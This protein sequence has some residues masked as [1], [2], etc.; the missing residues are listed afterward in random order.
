MNTYL[1]RV[2]ATLVGL[3]AYSTLSVSTDATAA[4]ALPST[5]NQVRTAQFAGVNTIEAM[6]YRWPHDYYAVVT[7]QPIIRTNVTVSGLTPEALTKKLREVAFQMA[8]LA[9]NY[10]STNNA[11]Q[12]LATAKEADIPT[13]FP[14]PGTEVPTTTLEMAQ[15]NVFLPLTNNGT[16]GLKVPDGLTAET[17]PI[18]VS[19]YVFLRFPNL[20]YFD[21]LPPLLPW[22]AQY[23]IERQTYARIFTSN[24]DGSVTEVRSKA[25]GAAIFDQVATNSYTLYLYAEDFKLLRLYGIG[26][27]GIHL[28]LITNGVPAVL[29]LEA[30]DGSTPRY[31][32]PNGQ[33]IVNPMITGMAIFNNTPKIGIVGLASQQIVVESSTTLFG[34]GATWV[35]EMSVQ[36]LPESGIFHYA[37]PMQV[38]NVP[39]ASNRFWRIRVVQ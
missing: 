19:E 31:W 1:N 21:Q 30:A 36:S 12:L 2:L 14:E 34:P 4:E 16:D 32:L 33:P 24:P 9:T 28:S 3:V 35:T 15:I 27:I 17:M 38:V 29:A 22:Y 26:R 6:L 7:E 10:P 13:I 39:G 11:F 37:C 20:R 5:L 8:C 23:L 18:N 25:F